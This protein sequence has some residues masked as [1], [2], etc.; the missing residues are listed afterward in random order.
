MDLLRHLQHASE[1]LVFPLHRVH[2]SGVG[3]VWSRVSGYA[4]PVDTLLIRGIGGQLGL[5]DRSLGSCLYRLE[6]NIQLH[7][8]GLI[9]VFLHKSRLDSW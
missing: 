5:Q 1:V 8:N 3:L 4:I 2:L 7:L 9:D 6:T